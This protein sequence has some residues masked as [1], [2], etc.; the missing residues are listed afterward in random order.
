MWKF[1]KV[2]RFPNY[3][4]YKFPNCKD[5][6]YVDAEEGQVPEAAARPDGGE[7]VARVGRVVRQ[8]RPQG[9]R[10]LL[11][12]GA[13]DRGGARGD[14]ALHQARRQD[15]GARVPGQADH[16]ETAGSPYGYGRGRGRSA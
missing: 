2:T 3:Q 7:G 12:D 6:T 10:A 9:A 15:L 16:Q 14:D 11:D 1:G 4:I 13:P 5:R 8:L